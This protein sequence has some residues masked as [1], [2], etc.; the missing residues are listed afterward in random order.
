MRKFTLTLLLI[1]LCLNFFNHSVFAQNNP[2]VAL[3]GINCGDPSGVG[4]VQKCCFNIPYEPKLFDFPKPLDVIGNLV[5]DMLRNVISPLQ[6]MQRQTTVEPCVSGAMPSTQGDVG[7]KG[8]VCEKAKDVPLA[9]LSKLCDAVSPK[10][11]SSCLGC[12]MGSGASSSVGVWTGIGCIYTNMGTF[13]QKTVFGTAIGLAGGVSL[14]CIIYAAFMMQ[15][16]RANPERIKKSQELLTSCIMGL[17]LI[18]FSVF[19]LKLIGVDILKI[20]GFNK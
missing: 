17:M 5:N 10:E 3:P 19:I 6:S 13:I 20:P 11:K 7:N 9:V 4:D 15:T 14:L 18:I 12:I 16:S 1:I 8:C 2:T